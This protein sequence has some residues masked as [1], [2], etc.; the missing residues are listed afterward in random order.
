MSIVRRVEQVSKTVLALAGQLSEEGGG[1]TV[2]CWQQ[3][4]EWQVVQEENCLLL[5]DKDEKEGGSQYDGWVAG[6]WPHG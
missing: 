4:Q 1:R 5:E 2:K 6:P 3:E